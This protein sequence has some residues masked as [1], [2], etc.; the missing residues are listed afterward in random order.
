MTTSSER[1]PL[2]KSLYALDLSLL[3]VTGLFIFLSSGFFTLYDS[4]Y[5]AG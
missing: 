2:E 3:A 5:V 1:L 4:M